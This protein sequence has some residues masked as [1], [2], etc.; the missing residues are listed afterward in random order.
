MALLWEP[1]D[2]IKITPRVV[3]QEVEGRRLQPRGIFNL[4][5]N[6]FTGTGGISSAIASNICG[7]ARNSGTIPCLPT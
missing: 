2:N 6:E 7:L 3:Y 5:D 4:F 1:T